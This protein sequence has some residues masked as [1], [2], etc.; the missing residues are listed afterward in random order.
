MIYVSL[1]AG[2]FSVVMYRF[3]FRQAKV[4]LLR[5]T[6]LQI[7]TA[8]NTLPFGGML[9]D[10]NARTPHVYSLVKSTGSIPHRRVFKAP[11]ASMPAWLF[12]LPARTDQGRA[13]KASAR[14]RRA[15]SELSADP[16]LNKTPH[17]NA[18]LV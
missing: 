12:P 18:Y 14:M 11:A 4:W 7:E 6:W 16:R 15:T 13:M 3:H 8:A 2:N 1:S 5:L 9:A 17:A 10:L